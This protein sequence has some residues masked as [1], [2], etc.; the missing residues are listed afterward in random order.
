[1]T[2]PVSDHGPEFS[3]PRRLSH[4]RKAEVHEIDERADETEHAR[5]AALLD[6]LFLSKL[7]LHGTLRA[8]DKTGWR[9]EGTLGATVTQA[10]VVTLQ[11]VKTRLDL[12]VTRTWLPPDPNS[13]HLAEIELSHEDLDDVEPLTDPLDLGLLAI[14]E[15]AL[16][17]P[18]YPR[19]K[20]VEEAAVA[21][22]PP[23][24]EPL[25]PREKPFAALAGLRD[26]MQSGGE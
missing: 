7:R 5:V 8:V 23:G 16:A 4:L 12:A 20:G 21:A 17:L 19:A 2:S 9:F 6:L 13:N 10:C 22:I 18:S 3:R 14:E 26:K 1:M 15:L 24:A 25:A 11:P